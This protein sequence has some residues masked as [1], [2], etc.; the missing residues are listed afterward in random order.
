MSTVFSHTWVGSTDVR[1]YWDVFGGD[2]IFWNLVSYGKPRE[3][4]NDWRA[5]W[6][7][8]YNIHHPRVGSKQNETYLV[9]LKYFNIW[10]YM[11]SHVS[12]SMEYIT[13][14]YSKLFFDLFIFR[15]FAAWWRL[16]PHVKTLGQT[17]S[18][19]LLLFSFCEVWHKINLCIV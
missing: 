6:M 12:D 2:K 11:A 14:T 7:L 5:V 16:D 1:A 8:V 15:S 9:R 10:S 17:H 19:Q 4:L 18:Y 13:K 3:W